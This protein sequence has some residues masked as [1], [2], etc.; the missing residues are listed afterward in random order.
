[1]T[2]DDITVPIVPGS[3]ASPNSVYG[4]LKEKGE[5]DYY[6]FTGE[7]GQRIYFDRLFYNIPN[8]EWW[9]GENAAKLIAPSG[10]SQGIR[11]L[12]YAD[13][14]EP[15]TLK[16]SGTY[17]IEIDAI[18]E[19]TGTYSF[20]VLDLARATPILPDT[21]ISGTLNPGQETHLYQFAGLKNQRLFLDT[22]GGTANTNWTLY[23]S[24][25]N[26]IR[27]GDLNTDIEQVLSTSGTYTLAIRGNNGNTPVNYSF[28]VITPD[29]QPGTLAFNVPVSSSIGEK[30]EQDVYTFTGTKGQRV[31]LDTLMETPNNKATLV[32]PSGTKVIDSYSSLLYADGYWR[33]P[34]SLPENGTYSLTVD[35]D[36]QTTDSYSFRLIDINAAPVLQKDAPSPTSG[37]LNPGSAIQF[38]KFTGAE[39]DRIYFDSQENSPNTNWHLYKSNND[40]LN[41]VPLANDFEQV[42]PGDGTYYLML[43]GENSAP[44]NYKVQL[45][46]TRESPIPLTPNALVAKRIDKLGEQDV[47]TFTGTVGQTLY[48]DPRTG[49]SDI[50]VKIESPSGKVVLNGN[51]GSDKEPFTLTEPGTYKVTVD[52]NYGK[53]GDYSFILSDAAAAPLL[54]L[55]SPLSGSVAAKETVLYQINGTAGQQLTIGSSAISGAEWVLYTPQSLLNPYYYYENNRVG[56]AN[57]NT[58]FTS[59]LPAD[60]TYILALQNTSAN[61]VSYSNIQVSSTLPPATTN[62]GLSVPYGG[63]LS[64]SGEV[65]EYSFTAASGT[66]VYFDGQSNDSTKRISLLKPNSTNNFVF[67]GLDAQSDSGAYQLTQTGSYKLQVYG[68]PATATGNYSFQLVDLKASPTL[69]LNAPINVS[70]NPRETKA[71]KFT[72]TV[73]QKVWLDGL[74]TSS[75]NVTAKLL[76]SSGRQVVYTGD[77]S[78]DIELQTLEADGEYYLVLQ[79]NN[80]LLTTANFRLLDNNAGA[81]NLPSLDNINVSGKFGASNRE[82]LLYKFQGLEG[83]RLYFDRTDGDYYNYY[84]L[85]SPDG[86][87][88]YYNSLSYDSEPTKLPSSGEYL[89]AFVGNNNPNNNYGVRIVTP[90]DATSS[91]TIGNTVNGEIAKA[92]Q[93]NTYTFAG[94]EGQRLWFDSLLAAGNINGTL[95]SPTNA[96]IWNSQSLGS[97]LE[98]AALTTLKETGNYRFVVDGSGDAT[99]NYSFRILDLAAAA[100]TTS[101]DTNITGTFGTSKRDA[102]VYKF[103]GSE[104]QYVYFDRIEGGGSNYSVYSPDGQRLFHQDLNYDEPYPYYY[105]YGVEPRKLPSSGEYTLVFNGTGQTND[106]YNLRMVTPDL[107]TQAHTIGN[108]ITGAMG[109]RENKIPTLLRA[110]P[111]NSC[112]WIACSPAATLALTCIR[113]QANFC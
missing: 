30:G 20:S 111:V 113:Q 38:Y 36:G 44:V 109:N 51:T 26:Q 10:T 90:T 16:E 76:N 28:K 85:Y 5:T 32:S 89:L 73:G 92:G 74:N 91:L 71:Y 67:S 77:L 7:V 6:T 99:G 13:D 103:T 54:P 69:V 55:G 60:G 21:D 64:A 87:R 29:V 49:N 83:Q 80:T 56:S 68:S 11:N 107:V 33:N 47:Y 25:N 62:S 34:V 58:G 39:G 1:M 50:A 84:Y 4:E 82:T 27:H 106:N 78:G 105:D 98:P 104:G 110:V 96:I 72:G 15:I 66:L 79:S 2:P 46:T 94:T 19:N 53:T 81:E 23:D 112:G 18:T 57:L 12:Q 43:R 59:T 95:Y 24:G 37:T 3:N 61:P 45:V 31:F 93:Q 86:N 8:P 88:F 14:G 70:L 42:L 48:F 75:T 100:K 41:E 65:D 52:G 102:V 9:L 40:Q 108:T 22:P 101:L 63:T 17:R 97:D 35:G